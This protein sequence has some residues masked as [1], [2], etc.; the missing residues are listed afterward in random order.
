L[1]SFQ[2]DDDDDE[3]SDD[4][5]DVKATSSSKPGI[6]VP[7]R[8]TAVPY[9]IYNFLFIFPLVIRQGNHNKFGMPIAVGPVVD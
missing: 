1:I 8:V 4:E 5:D 7:P 9:G 2:F 6:Y 3:E